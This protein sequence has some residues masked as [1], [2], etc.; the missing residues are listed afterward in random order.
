MNQL[1]AETLG[2][3][4][5]V[6]AAA[7]PKTTATFCGVR[8]ALS[9]TS[10]VPEQITCLACRYLARKQYLT[11]AAMCDIAADCALDEARAADA[12]G[13]TIPDLVAEADSYR[14]FAARFALERAG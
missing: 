14:A 1:L 7:L 9:S 11:W 4:P 12:A 3:P 13:V 8:R 6:A 5:E 10:T 2:L